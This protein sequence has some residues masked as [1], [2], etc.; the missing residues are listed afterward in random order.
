MSGPGRRQLQA[1]MAPV[2]AVDE[3][4]DGV[5]HALD[6]RVDRGRRGLV[7]ALA[8]S[9]R[10]VPTG[11]RPIAA[12]WPATASTSRRMRCAAALS[13]LACHDANRAA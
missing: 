4:G 7:G 1:C 8:Q 11:A 6:D 10:T 13:R 2:T 9:S 3:A 12:T 5:E